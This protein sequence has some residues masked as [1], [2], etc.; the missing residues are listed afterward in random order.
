MARLT[1]YPQQPPPNMYA[2]NPYAYLSRNQAAPVSQPVPSNQTTARTQADA[3]QTSYAQ[4]GPPEPTLPGYEPSNSPSNSSQPDRRP[5]QPQPVPVPQGTAQTAQTGLSGVGLYE[6]AQNF[7]LP[8]LS[9][10]DF[11]LPD[12]SGLNPFGGAPT[13]APPVP[14]IQQTPIDPSGYGATMEALGL[15]TPTPPQIS[16]PVPAEPASASYLGYLPAA[17]NSG[18]ELYDAYED[19]TTAN[20]VEGGM[21][22]AGSIVGGIIGGPW[23]ATAGTFVGDVIAD[24]L[25]PIYESIFGK[26]GFGSGKSE[27][28]KARDSGRDF[29]R[30]NTGIYKAP[31]GEEGE[32]VIKLANGKEWDTRNFHTGNADDVQ[33]VDWTDLKRDSEL[34]SSREK[35]DILGF[36][37]AMTTAIMLNKN[38]DLRNTHGV[39]VQAT[40]ASEFYNAAIHGEGDS[41]ENAQAI[42]DNAGVDW[43][44]LKHGILLQWKEGR[45]DADE[46]DA[47]WAAIDKY[48][49]VENPNDN[50][51]DQQL[52]LTDE[53]R[54]RNERE[55]GDN[56]LKVRTSAEGSV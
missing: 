51:A 43:G 39:N 31:T 27:G 12:F 1:L 10:P 15:N 52:D 8:E 46:R 29:W 24:E 53:E 41:R 44:N 26:T 56:T 47:H 45:I 36:F 35:Q 42:A 33:N 22:T 4:Q 40:T 3:P 25:A 28:E 54:A 20:L 37:N 7:E 49:G 2:H 5:G 55:L 17:V 13:A 32:S 50:R 23:G 18:I 9:L 38:H 6:V 16:T 14:G 34:G 21:T 11:S 48:Y 19:P 30:S